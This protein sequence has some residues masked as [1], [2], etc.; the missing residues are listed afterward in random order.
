MADETTGDK[1]GGD[2]A[3]PTTPLEV[4][5]G[6]INRIVMSSLDDVEATLKTGTPAAKAVVMK[7][8]IPALIKVLG[9]EQKSD[10]LA[11]MRKIVREMAEKDRLG[12]KGMGEGG[13]G[14]GATVSST[15]GSPGGS[16]SAG[17]DGLPEDGVS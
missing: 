4:L 8:A 9:E 1:I 16:G 14:G 5:R 13:D 15:E 7:T 6:R 3:I 2:G 10:E 11:E 12:I 17:L